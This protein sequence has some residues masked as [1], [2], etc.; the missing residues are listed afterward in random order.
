[1]PSLNLE[2]WLVTLHNLRNCEFSQEKIREICFIVGF[3]CDSHQK[4]SRLCCLLTAGILHLQLLVGS[5][6]F[7]IRVFKEDE[8]IAEMTETEVSG[9]QIDIVF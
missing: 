5:E 4:F 7:D 6:D 2:Q 3:W 1:M 9:L 8:I